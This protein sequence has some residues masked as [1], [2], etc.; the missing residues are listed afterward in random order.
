MKILRDDQVPSLP[1]A[2]TW[3]ETAWGDLASA[4]ALGSVAAVLAGLPVSPWGHEVSA[5]FCW[6]A[7]ILTGGLSL[8]GLKG[9]RGSRSPKGWKLQWMS[10]GLCVRF[11]SFRN[12]GFDPSTPAVIFLSRREIVELR[13]HRTIHVTVDSEGD[14]VENRRHGIEVALKDVDRDALSAALTEEA[15]RRGPRGGRSNHN[16]VSLSGD[17]DLFVELRRRDAALAAL[18][19]HFPI[20]SAR[21]EPVRDPAQ[22]SRLEQD[23]HILD[24][25]LAGD[26]M[27][28]IRVARRY[29][30]CSLT[31]A[32]ALV[33]SLI[34]S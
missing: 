31:E 10:E 33:E 29:R 3:R 18:A 7:A 1:E 26:K 20:G 8:L 16:P 6:P 25:V 24:L 30:G 21:A 15:R 34:R 11:R 12:N 28:A 19:L 23:D 17:G 2:Q 14:R 22:M 32:K 13:S 27:G 5:W 9:F 4:L